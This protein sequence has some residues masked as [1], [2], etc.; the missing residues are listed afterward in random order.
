MLKITKISNR[1]LLYN[2]GN[3][4]QYHLITYNGISPEKKNDSLC[5]IPET[6]A[7]S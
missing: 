7:V 5:C 3:Y 6:N 1:C 4:V 2:T